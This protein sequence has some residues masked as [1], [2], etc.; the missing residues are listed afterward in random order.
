MGLE[1][2]T[3]VLQGKMSNY[4]TDLF[5]PIFEEITRL[6][7]ARPYTDKVGHTRRGWRGRGLGRELAYMR[8]LL[9]VGLPGEAAPCCVFP[10][11]A[12]ENS[13]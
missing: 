11:R 10:C 4:A 2:V 3:S 13:L 12:C 8:L 9:A 1:R 7:G 5:M 6:T